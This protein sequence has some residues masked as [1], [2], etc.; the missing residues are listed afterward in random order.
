MP[1]WRAGVRGFSAGVTGAV[2]LPDRRDD[3]RGAAEAERRRIDWLSDGS[4]WM[5]DRRGGFLIDGWWI[6]LIYSPHILVHTVAVWYNYG[7]Q[8]R[9]RRKND[10]TY[11]VTWTKRNGIQR[12]LATSDIT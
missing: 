6:Y 2:E 3:R 10:M 1:E 7:G 11:T 5:R 12:T 8:P 4:S 9:P